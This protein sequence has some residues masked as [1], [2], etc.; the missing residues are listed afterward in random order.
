MRRTRPVLSLAA[1]LGA[2]VL[3]TTVAGTTALAAVTPAGAVSA[4]ARVERFVVLY[5]D[6]ASLA[7]ARRAVTAA[8][9]TVLKEN[10]AARVAVVQTRSATFRVDAGRQP[11]LGGV[12][13]DRYVGYTPPPAPDRKSVV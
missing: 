5:E 3:G 7:R 9:G 12:A 10:L 4:G 6:G 8:G 2:T 1:A 11:A 13:R